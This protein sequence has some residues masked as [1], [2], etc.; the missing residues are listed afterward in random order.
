[1]GTDPKLLKVELLGKGQPEAF[2]QG[3]VTAQR[4]DYTVIQ[5]SADGRH[6][7]VARYACFV[8]PDLQIVG[9]RPLRE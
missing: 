8:S 2:Q 6:R 4:F 3:A 5:N 1:M 7:Y 9:F